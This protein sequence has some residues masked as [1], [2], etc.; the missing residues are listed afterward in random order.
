VRAELARALAE[1]AEFEHAFDIAL[2]ALHPA[3][4]TRPR[5]RPFSRA[6]WLYDWPNLAPRLWPRVT[7]LT[8]A[9]LTPASR[10]TSRWA[11]SGFA[12][13]ISIIFSR[14]SAVSRL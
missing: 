11:A 6:A 2:E 14:R 7:L 9:R 1:Q 3:E 5:E 4:T 13:R 12:R 10:A 8:V